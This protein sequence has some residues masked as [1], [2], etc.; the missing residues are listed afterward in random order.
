[1]AAPQHAFGEEV[2]RVDVEG[3]PVFFAEAPEPFLAALM[4]RVGRADE[5]LRDGGLTHLV[6]HLA[7]SSI[8]RGTYQYNGLVEA[9]VTTFYASGSRGEVLEHVAA[10]AAAL[11]EPPLDR[12]D[13]EK[14]ILMAEA[15]TTGPSL[16]ARLMALRFGPVGYGLVHYAELG[17]GWLTRDD[18]AEWSQRRFTTANAALWLTGEP[19]ARLDFGLPDGRTRPPPAPDPIPTLDFPCE[20]AE[21][22][23]GVALSL[24]PERSTAVHAAFMIAVER[25]HRRLRQGAALSYAPTG[26][27][28]PLDG[29]FVHLVLNADCR[30][31]E[32]SGVRD[33]LLRIVDEL[34]EHGPTE[35]E[36]EWNRTMLEQALRD[37][38]WAPGK[39]DSSARDTLM[40]VRPLT[41][42]E[43]RRERAELTGDAVAAALGGGLASLLVLTPSRTPMTRRRQ[44]AEFAPQNRNPVSGRRYPVSTEW[45]EWREKSELV[46][47]STGFS[48]VRTDPSEV[49]SWNFPDCIAAIRL[50]SGALTV[51]GRDGS[52]VTLYPHR[53]RSGDEA[54]GA[55]ERALGDDLF[56][57]LTGREQELAPI[58]RRD[59]EARLGRVARE[60]D[61]LPDVLGTTEDLRRVAEV[62]RGHQVGLVAVTDRRLLF[63]FLGT[64]ENELFEKPLDEISE[65]CVKGL[66][67]KRLVVSHGA[68]TTE[69][70]DVEPAAR[71]SELQSL[72][73]AS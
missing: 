35:E 18:V 63:L 41:R 53:Y 67:T 54:V 16:Y 9:A 59:L 42:E 40:S 26:S 7:L 73:S 29:R 49:C 62:R 38:Y 17:L 64:Y 71:I 66:L 15:S 2:G 39:L 46:V 4:F 8:P 6:E 22:T 13:A 11:R 56:V 65:A 61:A 55:I 1:V 14:R 70:H 19:P 58:V 3:V 28:V 57:P 60:V 10:V 36:L 43:L 25:A 24:L 27:Y 5:T 69:F 72:L 44:L 31:Q 47:G 30:D 21:G 12:L 52:F 33:E 45:Q 34:A 50:L 23:G 32:A 68:E 37:P 48:Y 51:V 20:L